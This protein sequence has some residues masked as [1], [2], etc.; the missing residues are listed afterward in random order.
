M[1][2]FTSRIPVESSFFPKVKTKKN[3]PPTQKKYDEKEKDKEILPRNEAITFSNRFSRYQ[4]VVGDGS[5]MY[6]SV[7][8]GLW[9]AL[10]GE[11]LGHGRSAPSSVDDHMRSTAEEDVRYD[12]VVWGEFS[13]NDY[14]Q[15]SLALWLKFYTFVAACSV[16][17]MNYITFVEGINTFPEVPSLKRVVERLRSTRASVAGADLRP[18]NL[19]SAFFESRTSM[20]M[21]PPFGHPR[22]RVRGAVTKALSS[23]SSSSSS[24]SRRPDVTFAEQFSDEGEASMYSACRKFGRRFTRCGSQVEASILSYLTTPIGCPVITWFDGSDGSVD[25]DRPPLFV[26]PS[27]TRS[28]ED[29]DS[30]HAIHVYFARK[31]SPHYDVLYH[32]RMDR[33][34]LTVEKRLDQPDIADTILPLDDPNNIAIIQD[35]IDQEDTKPDIRALL[36]Q[37]RDLLSSPPNQMMMMTAR[38]V[39]AMLRENLPSR[40]NVDSSE[41]AAIVAIGYYAIQMIL[42]SLGL[43][44]TW[45]PS[46]NR[47]SRDA[48]ETVDASLFETSVGEAARHLDVI[49]RV[50]ELV[51]GMNL[52]SLYG[53]VLEDLKLMI[54]GRAAAA[55]EKE[56]ERQK[57]SK[58]KRKSASVTEPSTKRLADLVAQLQDGGAA[59]HSIDERKNIAQ[60]IESALSDDIPIPAPRTPHVRKQLKETV[61]FLLEKWLLA[62]GQREDDEEL[63]RVMR[64]S[65]VLDDIGKMVNVA[66]SYGLDQAR[67]IDPLNAIDTDNDDEEIEIVSSTSSGPVVEYFTGRHWPKEKQ[68][69]VDNMDRTSKQ[70]DARFVQIQVQVPSSMGKIWQK[71]K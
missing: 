66:R 22:F 50:R 5:C 9:Y 63:L 35:A 2:R 67:Y 49:A 31:P 25:D 57:K 43:Q 62:V 11:N 19:F 15:L 55:P 60:R 12:D 32:A 40:D 34:L 58:K 20:I 59:S 29:T 52:G 6:R 14:T 42:Q 65:G 64:D 28:A 26:I 37:E 68:R 47:R 41:G 13:V 51:L 71:R 46:G 54:Q 61:E 7:A 39:F 45:Y 10:F 8:N 48:I 16:I 18:R 38:N 69:F 1:S 56:R 3:Q 21:N 33:P 27:H 36:E 4:T 23:S 17:P 44:M 24:S 30:P 53:Y 70:A